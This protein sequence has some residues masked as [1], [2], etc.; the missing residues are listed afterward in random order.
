MTKIQKVRFCLLPGFI[1]E[2][3]EWF[4]SM[5]YN[6]NYFL[7]PYLCAILQKAS[8]HYILGLKYFFIQSFIHFTCNL[9]KT[10]K[11]TTVLHIELYLNT[12]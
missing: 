6:I 4:P 5:N 10:K 9:L 12:K 8:K 1:T 7:L 3:F 11:S 2:I